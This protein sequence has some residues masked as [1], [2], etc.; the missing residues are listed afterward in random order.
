MKLEL[1]PGLCAGGP[2]LSEGLPFSACSRT[3]LCSL[4]FHVFTEL[5]DVSVVFT[6]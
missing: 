1:W 6:V 3:K 2:S 5:G 4:L